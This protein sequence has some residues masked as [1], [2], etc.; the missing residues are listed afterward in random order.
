V[1]WPASDRLDDLRHVPSVLRNRHV[2]CSVLGRARTAVI[3]Y[4]HLVMLGEEIDL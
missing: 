3:R 2:A 1:D 4:D